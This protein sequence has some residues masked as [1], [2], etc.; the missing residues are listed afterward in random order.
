MEHHVMDANDLDMK[1][2]LYHHPINAFF[3]HEKIQRVNEW[4]DAYFIINEM[5]RL[6]Y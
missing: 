3:E 5:K 2:F 1:A 6:N 4:E